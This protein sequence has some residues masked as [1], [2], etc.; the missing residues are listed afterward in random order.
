DPGACL[1]KALR[2]G[3]ADAAATAGDDRDFALQTDGCA[4]DVLSLPQSLSPRSRAPPGTETQSSFLRSVSVS[5]GPDPLDESGLPASPR[6]GHA[7]FVVLPSFSRPV[8]V[9]KKKYDLWLANVIDPPRPVRK[10]SSIPF[11]GSVL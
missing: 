2:D 8:C 11:C 6:V 3:L 5:G 1:H 7:S 10:T 9:R 4:H